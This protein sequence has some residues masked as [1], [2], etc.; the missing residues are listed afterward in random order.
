MIDV[1]RARPELEEPLAQAERRVPHDDDAPTHDEW[2][3]IDAD[4]V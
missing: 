1:D 4:R 2:F 3:R